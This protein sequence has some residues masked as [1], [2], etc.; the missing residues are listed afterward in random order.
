M[1]M[2]DGSLE[3]FIVEDPLT[4]DILSLTGENLDRRHTIMTYDP[5]DSDIAGCTSL[6]NGRPLAPQG[7]ASNKALSSL[8]LMDL[9]ESKGYVRMWQKQTHT[10]KTRYYYDA[11]KASA[12]SDSFRCLLLF[13]SLM[14]TGLTTLVSGW[15]NV[16]Y[17]RII[18]NGKDVTDDNQKTGKRKRALKD[19]EA[20]YTKAL[21]GLENVPCVVPRPR[22]N[23][24]HLAP[25]IDHDLL[26]AGVVGSESE[27]EEQHGLQ[28]NRHVEKP[29]DPSAAP[30]SPVA[31]ACLSPGDDDNSFSTDSSDTEPP[32]HIPPI[33]GQVVKFRKGYKYRGA[34]FR[35]RWTIK[36]GNPQ[37]QRCKKSR[38]L[39]LDFQTWGEDGTRL[40][41][42]TWL[43]GADVTDREVS[44]REWQPNNHD[45]TQYVIAKELSQD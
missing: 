22:I 2:R 31:G 1:S 30:D 40:Y 13:E 28:G 24:K 27:G 21:T 32:Y 10:A 11:R 37:H 26:E 38:G 43:N 5:A 7:T 39:G 9:L 36:C 42:A 29:S 17:R 35:P 25:A 16:R 41:L 6:R 18:I 34:I 4:V 14:K 45:I 12:K 23:P 33:F 3:A 20:T 8:A 15:S 19:Q 44:H